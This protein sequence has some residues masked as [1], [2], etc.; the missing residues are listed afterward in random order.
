MKKITK[1]II[2]S[3]FIYFIFHVCLYA[4][5]EANIWYFGE[6][7]G[8]N[9]NDEKVKITKDGKLNT[10]EGCASICDENGSLLFYTNGIDVW[11]KEHTIMDNGEGLLGNKSSTQSAIIVQKPKQKNLY[12]IFTVDLYDSKKGLNYCIV[13]INLDN[14]KGSIIE[15]NIPLVA[16]T[17]EKVTAIRHKENNKV[18]IITHKWGGNEFYAY[19]LTEKG[20][21]ANPIIS[22]VGEEQSGDSDNSIGYMKASSDGK[23]LAVAIKG[24]AIFELLDFDNITGKLSNPITIQMN[25][26]DLTYGVEFSSD[27]SK[28]YGTVGNTNSLYQ[29]DLKAK[30]ITE[31][32]V[33]IGKTK[34]WAG[35]L[36]IAPNG[37]I[38]LSDYGNDHLNC[39]YYPNKAGLDCEFVKNDIFLE[40]KK[41]QLGLPTFVQTYFDDIENLQKIT[42]SSGKKIKIG[43]AFVKTILFDFNQF[44][45]KPEYYATLNELVD[46]LKS[47]TNIKIDISGHTDSDG[48]E[49]ENIYLSQNRSKSVASYIIGK[50]IDKSRVFYKGFGKNKPV[51]PNTTPENKA[52]N[53]RI[54]F[55]LIKS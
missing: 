3:Y 13:D 11:N 55:L 7:A 30:N 29:F 47:S 10:I 54:E 19:L 4:Q 48:T 36:Q 44:V 34:G 15:K 31:S 28:L 1:R 52:K 41:A 50:G 18:W 37:K 53:R 46:Y 40:G 16:P 23:K 27:C 22:A 26:G 45:I 20:L 33:L 8:I 42:T 51:L 12:Y 38:Y 43:E 24:K 21:D 9:F 49:Q 14:K 32:K 35:A 6:N 17:A 25:E 2:T 39:I 5:G